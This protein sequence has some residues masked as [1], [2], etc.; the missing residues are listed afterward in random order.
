MGDD[1]TVV[2]GPDVSHVRYL[3][4]RE[5]G[6]LPMWLKNKIP[7]WSWSRKPIPW[8]PSWLD[9][10]T[11]QFHSDRPWKARTVSVPPFQPF[12]AGVFTAEDYHVQL[13][14]RR[15]D[16]VRVV[17]FFVGLVAFVA[18]PPSLSRGGVL[19]F[20][21]FFRRWPRC[22][23]METNFQV[24]ANALWA[25]VQPLR[26]LK[27][28]GGILASL[29]ALIPSDMKETM[30]RQTLNKWLP[31]LDHLVTSNTG[32]AL[33]EVM[34]PPLAVAVVALVSA[35]A[36]ALRQPRLLQWSLR[37]AGLLSMLASSDHL[38]AVGG[39]VFVVAVLSY[40]FETFVWPRRFDW[41]EARLFKFTSNRLD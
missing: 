37:A 5:A 34:L 3:K 36:V 28:S 8:L 35:A 7:D 27:V 12:C 31:F 15:L 6:W 20:F 4:K 2:T 17:V 30:R 10:S 16:P 14:V 23:A 38:A 33:A 41:R 40:V 9:I 21:F 22:N 24:F 32:G 13:V 1:F 25:A 11:I 29:M 26:A 18:P 39:F 19:F